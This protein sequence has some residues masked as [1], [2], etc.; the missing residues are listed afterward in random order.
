M[1]E[2][3]LGLPPG[4]I[5]FLAVERGALKNKHFCCV[6]TSRV[7]ALTLVYSSREVTPEEPPSIRCGGPTAFMKLDLLFSPRW[8]PPHP[9]VGVAA[10]KI[11]VGLGSAL[12]LFLKAVSFS[13]L[14]H[15]T[16]HPPKQTSLPSGFP[17]TQ[18][19]RGRTPHPPRLCH[20]PAPGTLDHSSRWRAC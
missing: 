11:G 17:K 14:Y 10:V 13:E 8:A 9:V 1:S 2:S 5:L 15:Q 18:P 19:Y 7:I 4:T 12:A 16:L 3:W 20:Q 6:P